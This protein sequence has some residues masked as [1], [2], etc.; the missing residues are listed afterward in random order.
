VATIVNSLIGPAMNNYL[1][2]LERELAAGGYDD[3]LYVMSCTGGVI[4]SSYARARPVLTIGSGPV[5]GLIGAGGLARMT[6]GAKDVITA[7]MGGTTFDVGVVQHGEPLRRRTTRYG[8][9]EYFVPTLDVRSVGAGGGSIVRFDPE[10]RTLRVGPQSAGADPGPVAYGRGGTEATITDADLVLGYLNPDYFLGGRISLDVEKAREALG[11]AGEPLGFSVEETAAAAVRIV[12]NQMADAIRLASV[13]QGYDPRNH[14]MYAYGGAGPVH[15]TGLAQELGISRIVV[16][17]GDLASGWSALGVVSSDAVV[18]EEAPRVMTHPF[19]P[20]V[21]NETWAV[22]EEKV[23]AVMDSHNVGG[24]AVD[25][26]RSVDVRY[27]AQV[28][29]VE[30][31]APGGIYDAALAQQLV[32]AFEAEYARLYGESSGYPD[33]GYMMSAMRLTARAPLSSFDLS[34]RGTGE[35]G[36]GSKPSPKAERG[37]IFYERGVERVPTPIYDG[38]ALTGDATIEGPAI[39]EF[40]DTTVVVRDGQRAS[41]DRLGSIAI[42]V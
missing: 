33:A 23:G 7:D 16:P 37:V 31:S 27:A 13:Q 11:R 9:Y 21:I 30:V 15:A 36:G 24:A 3:T 26:Q 8:Q 20:E 12:D 35:G 34:A 39:I 29:E 10:F 19:D 41:Q 2:D 32:D 38:E 14:L 18:V 17:L 1:R 5:A 28:N 25:W 22:L 42:D 4:D 6:E 40:V